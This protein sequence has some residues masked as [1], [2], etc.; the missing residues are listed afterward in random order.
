MM[1]LVERRVLR[2]VKALVLATSTI[3]LPHFSK[4]IM[5]IL[6]LAHHGLVEEI[7]DL[8]V[9][10]DRNITDISQNRQTVNSLR[11]EHP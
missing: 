2:R 7:V 10:F 1:A 11:S 6:A 9:L 8:L 3:S 5:N 4:I